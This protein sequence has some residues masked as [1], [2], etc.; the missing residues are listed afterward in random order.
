MKKSLILALILVGFVS[1]APRQTISGTA[2]ENMRFPFGQQ[3]PSPP[4]SGEAYLQPLIQLDEVY[5]YPTANSITFAPSAHSAW[6][7]HGAMVVIGIGGEGLY[8]E[9]GKPA[10][11]IHPGDVVEI[12]AGTRHF[13]GAAPGSWFQQMVIYDATWKPDAQVDEDNT[14]SEEYYTALKAR[15]SVIRLQHTD[16]LMFEPAKEFMELPTFNGKIR[17]S[18]VLEDN[19]VA[20]CPG[21]HYV[22]FEPGVINAWHTH[23]GGQVLICTDGIGYHQIEGQPVEVMHPGDVC[24]CPPGVKHWHGAAPGSRFAHLA[25]NTNPD[26]PGVEWFDFISEEEYNKLPKE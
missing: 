5:N 8:Q 7:R 14:L 12:P 21:L 24:K 26:R 9:D 4:F 25:A 15:P 13:H 2:K 22:V 23:S 18:N 10:R 6:H 20:D 17:L 11:L 3:L 16:G 1:C 19:N